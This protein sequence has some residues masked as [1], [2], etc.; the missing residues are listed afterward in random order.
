MEVKILM[1]Q[2]KS[3]DG[4]VGGAIGAAVGYL[5]GKKINKSLK[6]D[7]DKDAIDENAKELS[8]PEMLRNLLLSL[9]DHEQEAVN[10]INNFYSSINTHTI[11]VKEN[12]PINIDDEK[13]LPKQIDSLTDY[14]TQ[15]AR[16]KECFKNNATSFESEY[17]NS[18]AKGW[19]SWNNHLRL[20]YRDITILADAIINAFITTK[21]EAFD[22]DIIEEKTIVLKA[23]QE[24]YCSSSE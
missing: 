10:L 15:L 16:I 17:S 20:A 23:L 7:E 9:Y 24:H 11:S 4:L 22:I 12:E 1:S 5:I 2:F 14:V 6:K 13:V 3:F 21:E 19:S 18:C 8:E